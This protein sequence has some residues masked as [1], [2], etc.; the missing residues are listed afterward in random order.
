MNERSIAFFFGAIAGVLLLV[1]AFLNLVVG[2]A[3][4]ASGHGFGG[5]AFA[6]LEGIIGLVTLFFT[7]I[8]AAPRSNLAFGAGVVLIVLALIDYLLL[9]FERT[10][11]SLLGVVFTLI[12]GIFYLLS[13]ASH[14]R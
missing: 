6:V 1:G 5:V 9:D 14:H 12:A 10:I 4:G 8:A 7:F 2:I 11:L 13:A 3:L